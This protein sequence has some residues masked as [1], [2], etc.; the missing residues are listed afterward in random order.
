MQVTLLYHVN[1]ILIKCQEKF[2]WRIKLKRKQCNFMDSVE[3]TV[4]LA[5]VAF[6]VLCGGEQSPMDSTPRPKA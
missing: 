2:F 3:S 5:I 6:F 1:S 4:S